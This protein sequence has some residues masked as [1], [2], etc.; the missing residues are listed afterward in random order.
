MVKTLLD[1][2]GELNLN[3]GPV[4]N[5]QYANLIRQGKVMSAKDFLEEYNSPDGTNQRFRRIL[6]QYPSDK[7]RE[8]D[9]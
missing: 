2:A 3:G 4:G 6:A 1:V 9:C 7:C 8:N 5:E